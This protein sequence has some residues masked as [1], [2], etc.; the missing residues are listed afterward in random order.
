MHVIFASFSTKT[1]Y[2]QRTEKNK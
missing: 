1:N 2:K